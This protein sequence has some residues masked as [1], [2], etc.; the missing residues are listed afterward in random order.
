MV[1]VM[2][3]APGAGKG[4]ISTRL[5]KALGIPHISSGDLIREKIKLGD[6]KAEIYQ[7][8]IDRGELIS[9][10]DIT[11]II[12]ERLEEEDTKNGFIFD[13]FPRNLSQTG[14]C[15]EVLEKHGKKVTHA[16]NL[17]VLKEIIIDR[18]SKRRVCL[19]CNEI[20]HLINIPPKVEG[21]CDKCGT[22]LIQRTD[23]SEEQV[24]ARLDVYEEQTRPLID[25]YKD[26]GLL[27]NI[28]ILEERGPELTIDDILEYLN[29]DK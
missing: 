25:Y 9:D 13:G 2:L 12:L 27:Y 23:D 28:T 22:E 16:I 6:E 4:T 29:E 8:I 11:R 21:I 18:L 17:D 3:G 7:E 14:I 19:N 20:Y 15:D 26:K 10:E 24:R 5:A 1:I